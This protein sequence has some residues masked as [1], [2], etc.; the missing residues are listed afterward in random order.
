M[1]ETRGVLETIRYRAII[2]GMKNPERA[3]VMLQMRAFQELSMQEIPLDSSLFMD[4]TF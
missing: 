4:A 1:G 3:R 2:E